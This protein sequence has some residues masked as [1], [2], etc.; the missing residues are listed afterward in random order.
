MLPISFLAEQADGC[1][2]L[3]D[4]MAADDDLGELFAL[5]LWIYPLHAYVALLREQMGDEL[6]DAVR[7]RQRALLEEACAGSGQ[8]LESMFTLIDRGLELAD[9][10]MATVPDD[11]RPR[12]ETGVALALLLGMPR[13]PAVA[14]DGAAVAGGIPA[15]R[16][17]VEV[18][19]A[20]CLLQ[21][22]DALL[23]ACSGLF[24]CE[25]VND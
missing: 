22:R 16:P 19:L 6:A 11:D 8:R 5:G 20:H 9:R 7:L 24:E 18:C 14:G 23:A 3:G 21:A 12:A 2:G 13:L 4:A 10:C 25:R 1:P 15:L 17:D